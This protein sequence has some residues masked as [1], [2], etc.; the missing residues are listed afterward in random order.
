MGK[1]V[2]CFYYLL[3]IKNQFM[4][5]NFLGI[6]VSKLSFDVSLIIVNKGQKHP[7]VNNKFNNDAPG[8]LSL[9]PGLMITI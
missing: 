3:I 4:Q 8:L 5:K 7:I 9:R 2:I 6:D 1:M